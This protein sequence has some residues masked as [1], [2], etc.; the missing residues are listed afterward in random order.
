MLARQGQ[1]GFAGLQQRIRFDALGLGFRVSTGVEVFV[2]FLE[3][4]YKSYR[5]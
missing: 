5:L 1:G 4:F 2:G 3:G